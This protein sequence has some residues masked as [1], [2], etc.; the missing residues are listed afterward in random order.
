M[1]FATGCAV[2]VPGLDAISGQSYSAFG[3]RFGWGFGVEQKRQTDTFLF[4]NC[5]VDPVLR[6]LRRDGVEC[7]IE[8]QVFDLLLYLLENDSRLVGKE[9][10]VEQIWDGRAVSDSSISTCIKLA[11]QAI[12]DSG[13]R[14]D[15]IRTA[16]RRGFR[17]VGE[18]ERRRAEDPEPALP[19]PNKPSIAVMPFENLSSD[20]EQ[21]YFADGM[22]EDII[23]ELSRFEYLFVI[24]R[25]TTFTYKGKHV[26]VTN[27][28]RELGVQYVLEGSV[29]KAGNRVRITAQLIDGADGTHVWADRYDGAVD[30]IFDLQDDVTARVVGSLARQVQARQV[31]REGR[32]ARIFDASHELAW[33]ARDKLR[34]A[35][36]ERDPSRLETAIEMALDAV[37][38]NPKCAIAYGT[39]CFGYNMQNLYRW[40]PDPDRAR[41]IALDWAKTFAAELPNAPSAYGA[42]GGTKNGLGLYEDAIR[43]FERA[44]ELNPNDALVLYTWSFCEASAGYCESAKEHAHMGLRL[45]PKDSMSGLACLSLAMAAFIEQ[46][47]DA[48]EEW[49]NKAIQRAPSAPIRRAL[50]IVHAAKIGN[51]ALLERHLSELTQFAPDFIA[52]LF[53][54]ENKPFHQDEHM[55]M[56][57]DGLRKAGL[58]E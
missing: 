4:G 16:P 14:Q 31:D 1:T 46:D 48:F 54:G 34:A 51:R 23:T 3:T 33:Q 32:S 53:R 42:L 55:T 24:A 37:E 8:P 28:A 39:L 47:D 25:N 10:L 6:T 38:I 19:L 57:L 22:T 43:D 45:S 41:H 11:R 49:G 36:A 9:E 2:T 26:D 44:H 40:G 29:R 7:S 13:R 12:G 15:L 17:F 35:F 30:D 56:L 50:M 20:P 5:T 21:D 27:V 18:L 52:S 58:P